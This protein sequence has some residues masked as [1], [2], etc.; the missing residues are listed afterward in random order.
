MKV[1][2]GGRA[3]LVAAVVAAAAVLVV[4]FFAVLGVRSGVAGP[5]SAPAAGAPTPVG[6]E[7][8]QVEGHGTGTNVW[9]LGTT[10]AGQSLELRVNNARALRLEPNATSPN[11]I[12]GNM[13]NSATVGVYGAAIGG[14]GQ[15]GNGNRVTDNYGTVGGGLLNDAGLDDANTANQTYASDIGRPHF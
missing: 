14:G 2:L 10:A 8:S 12:G 5:G 4:G 13:S 9:W 7:W 11:V 1:H 6:H 15:T 3:L